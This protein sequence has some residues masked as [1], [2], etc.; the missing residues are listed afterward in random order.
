M[1]NR[2]N[3]AFRVIRNLALIIISAVFSLQNVSFADSPY[4]SPI[5]DIGIV[6]R[7]IDKS[8]D[9]YTK[10]LG[11]SEADPFE[12]NGAYAKRIGLS[13]GKDLKIRVF[14]LGGDQPTTKVKLMSFGCD[15]GKPADNQYI[16]SQLGFSYLTFH[17]PDL[18]V[19]LEKA[20]Q[21][22]VAPVA[23]GPLELPKNLPQG[24]F[25]V[26]LRDPDGNFIELVGPMP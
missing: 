25:L 20:H 6:V 11:L 17:V 16:H 10:A 26:L 1:K 2:F 9:F 7:D 3:G 8:A 5:V 23:E 14:T 21:A 4:S 24:I 15:V 12:V 19:A 13:D 18:N 22:G